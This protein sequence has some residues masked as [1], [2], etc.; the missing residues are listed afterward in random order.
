MRL[1]SHIVKFV[2]SFL[3][4]ISVQAEIIVDSTLGKP[5]ISL[6]GPD[7]AIDAT[8]GIQKGNNL[9]HSFEIFDLHA[10]E[11][12]TFYVNNSIQRVIS[13]V[14]GGQSSYLDGL[15]RCTIPQV[16]LFFLNPS[17]IVFGPDA[18][19][20]LSGSFYATTADYLKLGADGRFDAT[21]PSQSVLTAA[22]PS[23]FGFLTNTPAQI[24]KNNSFLFLA[25]DETFALIGGE[26]QLQDSRIQ[27]SDELSLNSFIAVP[28]G[29]IQLVSVASEGEVS[30]DFNQL[31]PQLGKIIITDDT[32][33]H[34]NLQRGIANV[35]VSGSGGGKVT[36]IADQL[37]LDN[38]YIFVDTIGTK[39][40]RGINIQVTGRLQLNHASR[41]TTEVFNSNGNQATGTAGQITI[42]ANTITLNDGS[43][44]ASTSQ[45]TSAAGNITIV[46]HDSLTIDGQFSVKTTQG[47]L[48]FNSGL[49]TN[50]L[51]QGQGGEITVNTPQLTLTQGGT[52]RADTQGIGEAG[53]IH[54]HVAQ[55][56]MTT[57][58][59]ISVSAGHQQATQGTGKGGELTIDAEK[60]I[61]LI[62][63]KGQTTAI[64]S[65]V[66]TAGQGG[67]IK[68]SAPE[69]TITQ[70]GTIQS[71][72]DNVGKAGEI[73]IETEQLNLYQAEISC[74]ALQAEGG[75]I[76]L[77]ITKQLNLF[78]SQI[79]AHSLGQ[80]DNSGNVTIERPVFTLLADSRILATAIAGHGGNIQIN[81][82][83]LI[84]NQNNE[85]NASSR[86]GIDGKVVINAPTQDVTNTLLM[87]PNT[88]LQA[89]DWLQARCER[90]VDTESHLTV[91]DFHSLPPPT[92]LETG[93][94]W[95]LAISP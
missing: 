59:K 31:P 5:A 16:D 24:I 9:F 61:Q 8:L 53:N 12:A 48:Q 50:T 20:D 26:L 1:L 44:I 68:I 76:T 27:I 3:F 67:S 77:H 42:T 87:L 58:G 2:L 74:R 40:G 94:F 83:H 84:N 43:Q 85:L 37:I 51:Q 23:A 18:R 95:L 28:S 72:S 6:T 35:D 4:S 89:E 81:T 88:F 34:E 92:D 7:F 66:F 45:T 79:T 69:I 36:L 19:L 78:N 39:N 63:Q 91:Q 52:I 57:G 33:G 49:L 25:T 17:G 55:L 54:I 71:G 38:A 82:A 62:G 47:T 41:I 56:T 86:L 75:N 30:M 70:Q 10:N 80:Q 60:N 29:E 21:L 13:R 11:S 46:A 90:R 15:L 65:N 73:T 14:T 22:P 93:Q 64:V 32:Q